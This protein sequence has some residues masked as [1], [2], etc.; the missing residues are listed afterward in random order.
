MAEKPCV[1]PVPSTT[2]TDT[3]DSLKLS[4]SNNARLHRCYKGR[5]KNTDQ[6]ATKK[7]MSFDTKNL[8]HV[9]KF[10][11]FAEEKGKK[12]SF[13]SHTFSLF[14]TVASMTQP[15]PV[16]DDFHS[17]LKK[18]GGCGGGEGRAITSWHERLFP[19]PCNKALLKTFERVSTWN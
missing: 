2:D 12:V 18:R 5:W 11:I 1:W 10:N 16:S 17:G 4:T 14:P 15:I 8:D 19:A 7:G 13:P 3:F 9:Y 6:S